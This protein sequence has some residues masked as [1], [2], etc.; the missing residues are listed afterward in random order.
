MLGKTWSATVYTVC[1][2]SI[3]ENGEDAPV[4]S[5]LRDNLCTAED[6]RPV[7]RLVHAVSEMRVYAAS[8]RKGSGKGPSAVDV[9]A[10]RLH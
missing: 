3:A 10:M 2:P 6:A 4:G 7:G 1:K 8:L 5:S 9:T